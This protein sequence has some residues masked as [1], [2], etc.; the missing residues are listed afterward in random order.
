MSQANVEV[1][2]TAYEVWNAGDM[3]TLRELYDP[4]IELS[5]AEGWPEPGPYVGRDAVMRQWEQ[6]RDT[7]DTD[8]FEL[9]G[10]FI[11]AA[12]RVAVSFIWH[13]AGHGPEANIVGTGV[14]TVRKGKICGIEL[15]WNQEEALAAAGLRD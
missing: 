10:D 5:A 7:W 6:M 11:H 14:Y 8:A 9:T 15:F 1:V 3:E 13:G 2:R 12:D 4:D